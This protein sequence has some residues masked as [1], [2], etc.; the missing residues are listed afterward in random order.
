VSRPPGPNNEHRYDEDFGYEAS[1]AAEA[2]PVV[3]EERR[4]LQRNFSLDDFKA[5]GGGGAENTKG[6]SSRQIGA[7]IGVNMVVPMAEPD[8]PRRQRRASLIGAIGVVG[9]A[10]GGVADVATLGLLK[11]RKK[12]KEVVENVPE[13]DPS[14][15]MSRRSGLLDRVSSS[16]PGSNSRGEGRGTSY[17]DRVMNAR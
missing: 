7:T 10:V 5:D 6:R 13:Y 8:K 16:V 12:P 15:D 4:R 9:E 17:S 2:V 14:K 11:E 1:Q 3:K